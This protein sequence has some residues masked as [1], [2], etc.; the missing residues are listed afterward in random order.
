[1]VFL[2]TEGD[3]NSVAALSALVQAMEESEM[4]AIV[5]KVYNKRATPRLGILAPEHDEDGLLRLV[6]CELPYA[7]DVREFE[8]GRLYDD[9]HRPSEEQLGA[10]DELIDAMMLVGE[11][12]GTE[13]DKVN[14]EEI[15]NPYY[16]HL[17]TTLTHR[18]LHAG[19]VLPPVAE[20]IRRMMV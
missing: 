3:E 16:Q 2:P 15:L 18:A 20:H 5:R 1:M 12:D 14:T 4:V 19:Q 10:M 6:Y 17:Y 11:D 7:E 9:S 8:F 13:V